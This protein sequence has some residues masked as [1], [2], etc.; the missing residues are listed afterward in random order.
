M[1]PVSQRWSKYGQ[2]GEHSFWSRD[3][4]FLNPE[5][6]NW[7]S[8]PTRS[9]QESWKSNGND[10]TFGKVGPTIEM[11]N[12]TSRLDTRWLTE[13]ED[14]YDTIDK[15]TK[16]KKLGYWAMECPRDNLDALW[17]KA[18]KLFRDGDLPE[19]IVCVEASTKLHFYHN[20]GSGCLKFR[21][22]IKGEQESML[23]G[24]RVAQSMDLSNG[25][26]K[27]YFKIGNKTLFRFTMN[28]L[29]QY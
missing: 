18:R 26:G 16:L 19:E 4:D 8:R 29:G 25:N 28:E 17:I 27:M 22:S 14:F 23:V 20:N 15:N 6:E 2:P 7:R 3:R 21:C 9:S 10:Q 13:P 12:P 1:L 24:K 5:C 11:D